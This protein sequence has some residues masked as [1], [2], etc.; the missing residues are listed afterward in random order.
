VKRRLVM[1]GVLAVN[2]ACGATIPTDPPSRGRRDRLGSR[3]GDADSGVA[4]RLA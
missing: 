1:L 2:A 3:L 4:N